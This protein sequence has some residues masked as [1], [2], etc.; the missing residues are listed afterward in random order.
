[1]S[2]VVIRLEIPASHQH[3]SVAHACLLEILARME[4]PPDEAFSYNL[5]LAL[6]EA[7][8]NIVDHA[9]K[10]QQ[11][12][13]ELTFRLLNTPAAIQIDIID[14]GDSFDIEQAPTPNLEQPQIRGY[15]LYL[16]RQLLDEVFYETQ[17]G[18]NHWRLVKYIK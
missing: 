14:N 2:E 7:C 12:R 4:T 15:G 13:I 6:Q 10:N 8:N 11:G 3:L 5:R 16:M 9:Y 18:Y 17:S 1:M